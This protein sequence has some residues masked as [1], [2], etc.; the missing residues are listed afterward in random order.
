MKLYQVIDHPADGRG[1]QRTSQ[2]EA[3]QAAHAAGRHIRDRWSNGKGGVGYYHPPD[4][5]DEGMVF[6]LNNGH[7][8]VVSELSTEP[9]GATA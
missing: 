3:Y 6:H 4:E 8:L 2:V 9:E 5:T 7:T 1:K